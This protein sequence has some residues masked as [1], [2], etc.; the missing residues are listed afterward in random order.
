MRAFRSALTGVLVVIAVAL[1]PVALLARFITHDI[2]DT[3]RYLATVKPLAENPVIKKAVVTGATERIMER[4]PLDL[5]ASLPGLPPVLADAATTVADQLE[6]ETEKLVRGAVTDFVDSKTFVN[7]WVTANRSAHPQVVALLTGQDTER[8]RVNDGQV[9]ADLTPVIAD[10][11]QSLL[12]DNQIWASLI[13]EVSVKIVLLQ[14]DYLLKTQEISRL[15][16]KTSDWLPVMVIVLL[17]VALAL[18]RSRRTLITKAALGAALSMVLFALLLGWWRAD[19]IDDLPIKA[20]AVPAAEEVIN[21]L[22]SPLQA[23]L[24]TLFAISLVIALASWVLRPRKG[25]QA[26]S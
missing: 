6:Q 8:L 4:I 20:R 11:K 13:P 12:D 1:L 23:S 9:A 14:S 24:W 16:T 22:M 26:T 10:V 19:Y 17:V 18:S 21:A 15:L 5:I 3:E 2:T 7:M 25:R